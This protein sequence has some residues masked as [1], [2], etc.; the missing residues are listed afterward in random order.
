MT[1]PEDPYQSPKAQQSYEPP[2]WSSNFSDAAAHAAGADR[3]LIGH[4]PIIALL[5]IAQGVS[6]IVFGLFGLAFTALVYWGP[7]KELSGMRGIGLLFAG[8]SVPCLSIGVL[9]IVAGIFNYHY[10][11]RILGITALA[12]GLCTLITGYCAPTA[13]GLAIYGLIVYVNE[14]VIMAFQLGDSG[15]PRSEIRTAYFTR[16]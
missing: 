7:E 3:G 1:L 13:I 5:L 12:C 8:I 2:K 15:R 16:R 11:R 6:E 9:R 14:P 4:V 10:R